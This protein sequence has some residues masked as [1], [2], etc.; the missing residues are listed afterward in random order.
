MLTG[1]SSKMLQVPEG[2]TLGQGYTYG[3]SAP[4]LFHQIKS[5]DT[6]K[7]PN[8]TSVTLYHANAAH[9]GMFCALTESNISGA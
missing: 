8:Q 9:F 5:I 4:F 1:I 3:F 2:S 7:F 6:K